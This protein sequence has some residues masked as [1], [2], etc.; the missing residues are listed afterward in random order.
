MYSHLLI[1]AGVMSSMPALKRGTDLGF[2]VSTRVGMEVTVRASAA[3]MTEGGEM[4]AVG[5]WVGLSRGWW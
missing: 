1:S 5:R 3:I 4:E 2:E